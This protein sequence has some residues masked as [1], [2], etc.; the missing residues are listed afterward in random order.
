MEEVFSDIQTESIKE[1]GVSIDK[2]MSIITSPDV[3]DKITNIVSS[4][5]DS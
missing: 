5:D 3:V 2:I 4:L 1:D